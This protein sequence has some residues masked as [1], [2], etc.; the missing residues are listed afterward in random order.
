MSESTQVVHHAERQCFLA[1]IDG[2]EAVLEYRLVGE[3]AIDIHHT[4]VPNEL[5]GKGIAGLLAKAAL[6]YAKAQQLSVIPSCSYIEV[7]LQRHPQ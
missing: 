7:Y 5:R 6:D 4:F 2:Y 3:D 1:D